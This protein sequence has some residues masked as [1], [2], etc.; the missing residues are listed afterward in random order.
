MRQPIHLWG[1]CPM[2][3]RRHRAHTRASSAWFGDAGN[4][5]RTGM[6]LATT[7]VEDCDRFTDVFF[8]TA[9]AEKRTQRGSKG[10]LMFRDP[11]QDDRVWVISTGISTVGR[12]SLPIPRSRRSCSRPGTRAGR[13][14]RRSTVAT[15]PGATSC[16]SQSRSGDR[17]PDWRPL[18][19]GRRS[20]HHRDAGGGR[21][22]CVGRAA[23]PPHRTADRGQRHRRTR[24]AATV[25][26]F[27]RH[28][29]QSA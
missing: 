6:V 7:T 20:G 27:E 16:Q 13:R 12:A 14:C 2:G 15:R 11:N 17:R 9:G 18:P 24:S 1:N 10:A 28:L 21:D 26:A 22:Q 23:R 19:F 25:W 8:S 4:V 3:V 5:R 29:V